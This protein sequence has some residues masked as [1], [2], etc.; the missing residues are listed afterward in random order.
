MTLT[1][2][3]TRNASDRT[4]GFLASCMCEVAAGVYTGRINAGVRDRIWKVIER[5]HPLGSDRSAIMVWADPKSPSGQQIRTLGTTPYEAIAWGGAVFV[6]RDST[7]AE[8][9]S[10]KTENVEEEAPF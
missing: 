6:R 1:V 9:R 7:E 2:V 3:V 10:L 8:K 4:R 5:W